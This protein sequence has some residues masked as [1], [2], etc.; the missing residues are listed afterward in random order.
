MEMIQ[1]ALFGAGRI[2]RIHAGNLV[3]QPGVRLKYVVDV[4]AGAAAEVAALH[5]AS[6]ASVEAV[7]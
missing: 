2:G 5:G 4:H 7:L 3:R 6:V 1:V